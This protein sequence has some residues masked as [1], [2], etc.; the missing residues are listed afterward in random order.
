[1]ENEILQFQLI[2]FQHLFDVSDEYFSIGYI[3]FW[4]DFTHPNYW[5][6]N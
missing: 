5:E 2:L 4:I 1:M 3:I 6:K